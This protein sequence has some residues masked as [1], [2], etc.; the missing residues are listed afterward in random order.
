MTYRASFTN[1]RHLAAARTMAGLKQTELAAMAGLHVNS[2][3]RLERMKYLYGSEHA[4]RR[5]GEALQKKGILAERW[6]TAN[7]RI[8]PP[9]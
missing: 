8:H 1:G 6:P 3:K 4:V 5:I 7:V 9:A 2:V